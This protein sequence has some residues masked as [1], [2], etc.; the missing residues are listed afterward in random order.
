MRVLFVCSRN[1]LRSPTAEAVFSNRPNIEV[2]SS[3][4]APDAETLVSAELVDWADIIFAMEAVH[5]QRLRQQF[6]KL[7]ESKKIIV[8]GIPDRYQ[9]MDAK[10][11]TLLIDKVTPFL[12]HA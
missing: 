8:L 10:L 1:R 12:H 6:G 3:G 4:T 2:L 7:I 11:V 5:R 9:Y